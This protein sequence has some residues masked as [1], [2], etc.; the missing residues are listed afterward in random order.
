M[1]T[2]LHNTKVEKGW[3]TRKVV[4]TTTI[5]WQCLSVPTGTME[6]QPSS[7]QVPVPGK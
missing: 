6:I 1:A 2:E 7:I 4:L 3:G 5:A